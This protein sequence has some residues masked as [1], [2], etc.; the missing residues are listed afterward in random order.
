M[1]NTENSVDNNESDE[2]ENP[3]EHQPIKVLILKK[4]IQDGGY[5]TK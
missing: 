1:N 3:S 5:F 4:Y 2:G